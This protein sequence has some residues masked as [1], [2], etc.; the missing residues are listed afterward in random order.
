MRIHTYLGLSLLILYITGCAFDQP[1]AKAAQSECTLAVKIRN[2]TKRA[3]YATCFAYIKKEQSPRWRWQ[4]TNVYEL[5]P[6]KDVIITIDTFKSP[7]SVPDALGVLGVFTT[8]EEADNAIYEL[9]ADANKIDL[10]RLQKL[11]DKTVLLGIEKYGVVGDIFDYSFVP[12]NAKPHAIPELDFAVENRSG[13]PLY[14]TAFIYE[15]KED[16]PIWRYDKSPVIKIEPDQTGVIDVDTMTNQ[17]DRKYTRGFLAIFDESEKKQAYDS[18]YQLLEGHQTI[19]LGLLS[20]LENRKVILKS[21][22]YG[23]MGDV[24]DFVV[25]EPRKITNSK[26]ENI[27]YQPRYN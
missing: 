23:I 27:R 16:M 18:T 20:A 21:Q 12:D 24:I 25:K 1:G 15:K 19:N 6:D 13:K 5:I 10:D 11:R 17:Y 3:L 2:I 22:K 7:R 9:L 4:K 8:Y 14:A 26:S